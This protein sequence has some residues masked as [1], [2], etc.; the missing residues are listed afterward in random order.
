MIKVQGFFAHPDYTI[1]PGARN[2]I[3]NQKL[4]PSHTYTAANSTFNGLSLGIAQY[5]GANCG[6]PVYYAKSTDPIVNVMYCSASFSEV[7]GGTWARYGNS[8]SLE[9]NIMAA[10][11]ND[12]ASTPNGAASRFN[13]STSSTGSPSTWTLPSGINVAGANPASGALQVHCPAGVVPCLDADGHITVYQPNGYV[14]ECYAAIILSTGVICCGNC[15]LTDPGSALDGHQ[16]GMT[17]SLLSNYAGLIKQSD[18]NAGVIA[19][20]MAICIPATQLGNS[21][22]YP[23]VT[24]D[25]NNSYGGTYGQGTRF[26]IPQSVN[27]TAHSFDSTQ[28]KMIATAAQQYGFITVDTGGGGVTIRCQNAMTDPQFQ[29]SPPDYTMY[30]DLQWII[31]QLDV[32]V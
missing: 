8:A 17:A 10:S 4:S 9:T 5:N 22:V 30:D 16:G 18:I 27:L 15:N 12:F 25:R 21:I 6:Y 3:W 28:G 26:A 14:L 2:A 24:V 11:S 1:K 13:Y 7:S 32:V 31:S 20:A 23:A 29:T 19:H